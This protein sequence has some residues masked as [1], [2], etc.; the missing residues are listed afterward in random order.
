[1][2]SDI[3]YRELLY[4]MLEDEKRRPSAS[5]LLQNPIIKFFSYL[6]EEEEQDLR[7][8]ASDESTLPALLTSLSIANKS[9]AII[10]F[11]SLM[12]MYQ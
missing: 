2:I 8:L 12:Y 7:E 3:A 1:M 6:L 9:H 5:E 4:Q 11:L 10:G